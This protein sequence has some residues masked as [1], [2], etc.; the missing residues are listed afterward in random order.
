[1]KICEQKN[2]RKIKVDLK[3]TVLGHTKPI[4]ICA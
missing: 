2:N 1:M 3:K 4:N